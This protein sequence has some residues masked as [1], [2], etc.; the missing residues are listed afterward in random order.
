MGRKIER[1]RTIKGLKQET[2][3][4]E[5]GMTQSA[6]SKIERSETVED[7][8]LQQIA[9]ALDMSVEAIKNFSE[10][11]VVNYI[12]NNYEGSC[13][14]QGGNH[15]EGDNSPVGATAE[16]SQ[17][18]NHYNPMEKLVEVF[19]KQ[20]TELLKRIEFLEEMLKKK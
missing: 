2:L 1:I 6:L 7:D 19:E 16:N 12:Q 15:T 4:K 20:V 17:M 13:S 18:T 11:R 5:L 8:T 9:K 10:E 14:S 3:A